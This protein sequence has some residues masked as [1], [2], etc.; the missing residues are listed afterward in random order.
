MFADV[1]PKIEYESGAFLPKLCE[2]TR[3]PADDLRI[4]G[5][6]MDRPQRTCCKLSSVPALPLRALFA[7][8][9]RYPSPIGRRN[10]IPSAPS[11]FRF[12]TTR[13]L[14]RRCAAQWAANVSAGLERRVPRPTSLGTP[15]GTNQKGETPCIHLSDQSSRCWGWLGWPLAEKRRLSKR[16][17]AQGPG[18]EPQLCWMATSWPGPQWVRQATSSTARPRNAKPAK[19][20]RKTRRH[21]S[22]G[23]V[24]AFAPHMGKS[25][26]IFLLQQTAAG[27]CRPQWGASNQRGAQYGLYQS[28]TSFVCARGVCCARC[29]EPH[30]LRP[31]CTDT[32]NQ[33]TPFGALLRAGRAKI[34]PTTKRTTCESGPCALSFLH[35][36]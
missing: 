16:C 22:K 23:D 12:E 13:Y 29:V 10:F 3:I 17:L 21:R 27:V 33:L 18:P 31:I 25:S 28:S 14:F 36:A 26:W 11:I 6:I 24:R 9:F 34:Q 19:S 4:D 7:S 5:H 1:Q 8:L 20:A 2:N 15:L 32:A 30:G 35:V